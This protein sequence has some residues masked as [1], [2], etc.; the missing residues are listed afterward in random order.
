[1][2]TGAVEMAAAAL[3]G[4]GVGVVM[5]TVRRLLMDVVGDDGE[6]NTT[7]SDG[8]GLRSSMLGFEW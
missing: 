4:A 8:A 6:A 3:T 5:A 1:M 2:W 7:S